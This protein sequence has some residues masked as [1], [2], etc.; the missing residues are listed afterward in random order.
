M[1]GPISASLLASVCTVCIAASSG[2]VV[3]HTVAAP[4][5]ATSISTVS[6]RY[7]L[8]AATTSLSAPASTVL[9]DALNVAGLPLQNLITTLTAVGGV[10]GI[11]VLP[12]TVYALIV[13]GKSDQIPAAIQAAIAKERAAFAT[14]AQLPKTIAATNAAAIQKLLS[15]FGPHVVTA[16]AVAKKPSTTVD[17]VPSAAAA[18]PSHQILADALNVLGLPVQNLITTLTVTGGLTGILILPNTVYSLVVSGKSDQIP[19]AIQAAVAKERAAFKAVAQ[20]PRTIIATDVSAIQKLIGDFG[21]ASAVPAVK[22]GLK[23]PS[24]TNTLALA[25][26][27]TAPAPRPHLLSLSKQHAKK[28]TS[29]ATA[30]DSKGESATDTSA[31]TTPPSSSPTTAKPKPTNAGTGYVGRHRLKLGSTPSSSASGSAD[32]TSSNSHTGAASAA[33]S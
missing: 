18:V 6:E 15:D 30:P 24:T 2:T 14:L 10:T 17:V 12:N 32:D 5:P 28:T 7:V 16:A 21:A 23:T 25:K 26:S 11:V 9:I 19:A 33:A 20:L 22:T 1:K 31:S 8:T 4:P 13:S 27:T 29:T 3:S